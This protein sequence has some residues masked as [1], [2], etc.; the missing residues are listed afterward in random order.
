[1]NQF[2]VEKI[3]DKRRRGK[4]VSNGNYYS[5]SQYFTCI[6]RIFHIPIR[7]LQFS[8]SFIFEMQVEYL[9]KWVNY[10]NEDNSWVAEGE[11]NCD[12]LM[13]AFEQGRLE[14]ILG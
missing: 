13:A 8:L 6:A 11:M 10:P 1:M 14:T 9:L 7:S 12:D 3:V 2:E 4:K 5:F